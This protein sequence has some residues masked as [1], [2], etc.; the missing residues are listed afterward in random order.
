MSIEEDL[1]GLSPLV[2]RPGDAGS[3]RRV[4]ASQMTHPYEL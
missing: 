3:G 1:P 2:R 4:L